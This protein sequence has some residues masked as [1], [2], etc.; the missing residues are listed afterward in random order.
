MC[1][2]LDFASLSCRIFRFAC[3]LWF[4]KE[5]IE[6]NEV[7]IR[8]I[9]GPLR[10]NDSRDFALNNVSGTQKFYMLEI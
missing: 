2:L 9:I 5:I 8:E 3:G 1:L 4:C 10:S 6:E 7:A